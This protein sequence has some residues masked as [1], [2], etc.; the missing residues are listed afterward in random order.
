M[1]K[2]QNR[3]LNFLKGVGCMGVVLIHFP[4]PGTFGLVIKRLSFSA[5]PIF[6]LI[7]GYFSYYEDAQAQSKALV[8]KT[9]SILKISA[10]AI[11]F[12]F[13]YALVF[14][15]VKQDA[16]EFLSKCF[17]RNGFVNFFV[18][19]NFE[20]IDAYHLWF[21]P[22][23]LYSYLL[24]L[25]LDKFRCID[26]VYPVLPLWFA[27]KLAMEVVVDTY[28]F[29]YH[30]RCNALVAAPY[31]LLGRYFACKDAAR[32]C[33]DAAR[34]K[35]GAAGHLAIA[36]A[37]AIGILI[38]AVWN[39][40]SGLFWLLVP[41]IAVPLFLLAIQK[42]NMASCPFLQKVG[43]DYSLDVYIFHIFVYRVLSNLAAFA[44][45]TRYAVLA[46]ALPIAT[47]LCSVL[48]AAV[49]KAAQGYIH[50]RRKAHPA[51]RAKKSSPN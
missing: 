26:K 30:F 1:A 5:V 44:G 51:L 38:L 50:R 3:T 10:W 8:R 23:L 19:N 20:I 35:I 18:V 48:W 12:Y 46:W 15:L 49:S 43:A 6:L 11:G 45:L 42:P 33:K 37:S 22:S 17:S 24:L 2:T 29:S 4:L 36:C 14:H 34:S 41:C 9:V 27:A 28:G 21:L 39:R 47:I 13:L 40:Q 32:A 25:V 16:M 7:S 31:V